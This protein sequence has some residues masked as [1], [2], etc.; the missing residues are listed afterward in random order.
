MIMEPKQLLI[1]LVFATA[2]LA[3]SQTARAQFIPKFGFSTDA[4]GKDVKVVVD[5]GLKEIYCFATTTK[6]LP[7]MK[8][9]FVW[10][11]DDLKQTKTQ[12]FTQELSNQQRTIIVSRYA[13]PG[14]LKYGTYEV[15]MFIDGNIRKHARIIVGAKRP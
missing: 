9:K 5:P 8:F 2:L 15:D 11:H 10:T 1:A 7:D 6:P 3:L 13:P 14:G 12:V 4:E